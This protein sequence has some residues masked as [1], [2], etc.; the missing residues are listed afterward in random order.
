MQVLWLILHQNVLVT[1]RVSDHMQFGYASDFAG[2]D[3]GLAYIR[4]IV[5]VFLVQFNTMAAWPYP[6]ILLLQLLH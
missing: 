6:C 1:K 3:R 4:V 2:H 5:I